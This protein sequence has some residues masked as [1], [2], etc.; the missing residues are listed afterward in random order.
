VEFIF[1]VNGLIIGERCFPEDLDNI[2]GENNPAHNRYGSADKATNVASKGN[3][4]GTEFSACDISPHISPGR[5]VAQTFSIQIN[6]LQN[7]Y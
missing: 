6:K 2:G 5:P 3:L 1:I 4:Q 7:I